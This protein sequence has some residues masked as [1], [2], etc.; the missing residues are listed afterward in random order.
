MS[1]IDANT[2]LLLHCEGADASVT[3]TDSSPSAHDS[4][5][6]VN[7]AQIDTAQKKFG[8]SSALF[9]GSGDYLEYADSADWDICGSAVDSWTID[10][11]VKHVDHAGEECYICQREDS[12]NQW[13]FLNVS[14]SGIKFIFTSGGGSIVDT[15]YGAEIADTNWHH[16]ALIKVAAEYAIY[17]DGVQIN[18]VSDASTDTLA[19]VLRIGAYQAGDQDFEGWIDEI[20]VQHSNAFGAAP[21]VG[22]TDTITPP[23]NP[24]SRGGSQVVWIG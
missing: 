16:L 3:F 6:A 1:G 19:G 8:A 24:Y 20:R 14:S 4:T 2:K 13:K 23:S 10:F 11:W 7:N 5:P 18:Y 21:N 17:K 12:D 22:K 9:D 15:G